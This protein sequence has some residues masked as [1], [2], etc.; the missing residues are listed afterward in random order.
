MFGL[1]WSLVSLLPCFSDFEWLWNDCS[2]EPDSLANLVTNMGVSK[3]ANAHDAYLE[4][5][6]Y[7]VTQLN[8]ANVAMY[9]DAGEQYPHFPPSAQAISS[10]D[11]QDMLAG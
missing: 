8:L 6:N 5:V 1:F 3:C 11:T 9:I 10:V 2:S 7:A 4:C